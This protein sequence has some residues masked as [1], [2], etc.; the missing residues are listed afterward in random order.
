VGAK[1]G[2]QSVPDAGFLSAIWEDFSETSQRLIFAKFG[3]DTWIVVETQILDRKLWKVSIQGL[4]APNPQTLKGSNRYLIQSRL[5]VKGCIAERY[6]RDILFT[7]RCSPRAEEFP[8]SRQLFVRRTAA[9]LWGVKVAQF[10][11]FGLFSPYKTPKKQ[12]SNRTE[13]HENA[14]PV[15]FYTTGTW[16]FFSVYSNC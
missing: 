16:L 5:Q 7:P 3:N 12:G 10:S 15:L 2:L 8:R 4:F 6:C 11:D 1:W 14:V 13:T 9:E